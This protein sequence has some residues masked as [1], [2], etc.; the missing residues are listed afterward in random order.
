[1]KYKSFFALLSVFLIGNAFAGKCDSLYP[2]LP[3][4]G[5]VDTQIPFVTQAVDNGE[6]DDGLCFSYDMKQATTQ[7]IICTFTNFNEGWMLFKDNS[8][9][10]ESNYYK[11]AK[12]VIL[13][14]T[15]QTKVISDTLDQFHVDENG[16]VAIHH[17][18]DYNF[19]Q[20]HA[21][22][23]CSYIPDEK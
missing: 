17:E 11:G 7:K 23:S 1:M 2:N 3:P 20:G 22:A 9:T 21:V 12:T 16:V 8:I 15:G 4:A 18:R 6:Y 10:K 13:T 14:S 5:E 19:P